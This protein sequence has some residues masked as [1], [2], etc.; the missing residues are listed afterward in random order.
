MI[1]K[2]TGIFDGASGAQALVDVGGVGYVVGCSARTLRQCPAAGQLVSLLVETQVREDA[3]NLYGFI[4]AAERDWFRLLISVQGVGA[5]VAL[6][7]LGALSAEQLT[8][9][10]ALQDKTLLTQADGVGPKLAA[11]LLTELKDKVGSALMPVP[12][13][14]AGMGAGLALPGIDR[15]TADALSALVNLGYR[16]AEAFDAVLRARK[17]A[18]EA[19][20]DGLIPEALRQLSRNEQAA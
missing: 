19:G 20:L 2:L 8:Q 5:K 13:A 9:A 14:Q 4:D 15:L 10:I 16:R 11:R 7:I 17:I 6:A 18:P 1:G 3:I 12:A